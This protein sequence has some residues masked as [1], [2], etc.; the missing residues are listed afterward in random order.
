MVALNAA[1]IK[2]AMEDGDRAHARRCLA[3]AKRFALMA[4]RIEAGTIK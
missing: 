1:A 2:K 4:L 3:R